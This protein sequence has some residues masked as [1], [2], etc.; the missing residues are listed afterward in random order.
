MRAQFDVVHKP[1]V[2]THVRPAHWNQAHPRLRQDARRISGA[3]VGFIAQQPRPSGQAIRQFMHGCQVMHPCGQHLHARQRLLQAA[4][5]MHT[6]SKELLP[7]RRALPAACAPR[8]LPTAPGAHTTADWQGEAIDDEHVARGEHLPQHVRNPDHPISELMEAT[9]EA[10]DADPPRQIAAPVPVRR[11]PFVMIANI[12][13]GDDGNRQNLG[14]GDLRPHIT[15]M[16][17]AFHQRVNHDKSGYYRASDRRLLL[18]M[19]LVGQPRSCQRCRWSSTSNQGSF[20]QFDPNLIGVKLGTFSTDQPPG[21]QLYRTVLQGE[22]LE[23]VRGR[24]LRFSI[25]IQERTAVGSNAELLI[26]NVQVIA[27]DGRTAASPLPP[28]LRG[29]GSRLLAVIRAEGQNRW[30]YRMDTDGT[31]AQLIYRGLLSN[32]RYPAWSHDGQRIAVVDNNTWPWPERDPDPQNNLLASAVTVI[33]ADG[34]S[35]RQVYQT[36]SRK[37]SRCPFIPGP[38]N[39]TETPSLILKVS[40]VQWL[41]DNNR[42]A[43]TLLGY[44]EFCNGR[45]RGGTA[46][47]LSLT[48][49]SLVTSPLA[50]RA[51]APSINRNGKMLFDGFDLSSPRNRADGVWELDLGAQPPS[52]T[53]LIAYGADRSPAW[54]PDGRRFAV[55]RL[56]TSPSADVSE[57]TFA[58]MLYDRQNLDNPRMI[59]FADHGRSVSSLSWSPDGAYL[60]YT[61]ERFDGRSDIWWLDVSSGAT[62]PVTTDG[63]ALEA[64]WRPVSQSLLQSRVFLPLVVR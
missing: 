64:A 39:P 56:T 48:P 23:Q 19:M 5:Q 4:D 17:Q 30:L 58:I 1:G 13:G 46:D 25:V 26:D 9:I 15:A 35:A 11:R 62:G 49:P 31:N 60:V 63:Q 3:V 38:G 43:L 32:V 54:A 59:L 22:R 37:G 20:Y 44:A 16:P 42:I 47:I 12:L 14:V 52:E 36:Q 10:R 51:T 61:L 7:F 55:V 8:R 57:R 2:R 33:N 18:A 50:Q 45:R 27:A 21:W 41:P 28:A 34:S 6:P 29:D 24:T 40:S 53:P